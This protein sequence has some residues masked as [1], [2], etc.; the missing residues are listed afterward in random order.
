[1]NQVQF[2]LRC[3]NLVRKKTNLLLL[4][5]F[6]GV[7]ARADRFHAG[8]LTGV[9]DGRGAARKH[10]NTEQLETGDAREA[11]GCCQRQNLEGRRLGR[12]RLYSPAAGLPCC[13]RGCHEHMRVPDYPSTRHRNGIASRTTTPASASRFTVP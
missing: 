11:R 4:F 7:E 8:A 10:S 3:L 13:S 9:Y 5:S 12:C 6:A 2:Q 1:M